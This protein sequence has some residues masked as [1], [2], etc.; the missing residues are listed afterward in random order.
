MSAA[1]PSP[2][3]FSELFTQLLRALR[4]VNWLAR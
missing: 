2:D 3:I 4:A 1:A